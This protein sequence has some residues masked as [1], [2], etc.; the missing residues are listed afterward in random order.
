MRSGP[1]GIGALWR[2]SCRVFA[3]KRGDV[4][5]GGGHERGMRLAPAC[6]PT[7]IAG[8]Y[9]FHRNAKEEMETEMARLRGLRNRL[10]AIKDILEEVLP[11]RRPEQG[12]P[13]ILNVSFNYAEGAE[14][15]IMAL[16]DRRSLRFRLRPS[17][18]STVLRAARVGMNDELAHTVSIRFRSFYHH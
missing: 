14:S 15:P 16:K 3:L 9:G 8:M 1:K 10:Y 7:V 5:G 2:A 4:H 18:S 6:P 17:A 12:A 11:E 13:N